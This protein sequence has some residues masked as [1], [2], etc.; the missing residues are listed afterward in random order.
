MENSIKNNNFF[1]SK[2]DNDEQC[3]MHSQSYNIEIMISDEA[4]EVRKKLFHPL[5]N[6]CQN[7]L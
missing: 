6:I 2:E 5:K 3:V 4:D 7:N 1:S